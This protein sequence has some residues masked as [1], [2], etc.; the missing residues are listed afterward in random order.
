MSDEDRSTG[1]ESES[2]DSSQDDAGE[3]ATQQQRPSRAGSLFVL[4]LLV[5]A[6]GA[7][8]YWIEFIHSDML[9]AAHKRIGTLETQLSDLSTSVAKNE[10]EL[11]AA[12][13]RESLVAA[14]LD[15]LRRAQ[16]DL[17][18]SL[19]ALYA[20]ESEPDLDWV[21]AEV[22]YLVLAA[23]QRLALERD[24]TTATAAL[25]AADNRLRTEQHPELI[26]LREQLAGDI[27]TLEAVKMPDIE[28][29]AIY[30]ADAVTR[31][32][33]LPTKPIAGID[34]SFSRM[35][36]QSVSA[37]NWQGVMRA[38]WADMKSLVE[39]KDGELEDSVLFDPELRY[40]LQQSLRLELSSARL[41]VLQHDNANFHAAVTL[42]TD[43]LNTYYDNDDGGVRAII[44]RLADESDLDLEPALPSVAASLDAVRAKRDEVRSALSERP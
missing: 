28:G 22:E 41:A 13:G 1:E 23:G 19:K 5:I 4:L 3:Q 15:P 35:S 39:V 7:G 32:D 21:L 34:M 36:E 38:V 26:G 11:E 31:V 40:F 6:A 10:S 16:S 9:A 29:L 8:Y 30:L 25:K 44:A 37:Q 42:V 43:L 27:A 17:A 20:K 24:V 2:G 12:T 33:K 18:G 14:D